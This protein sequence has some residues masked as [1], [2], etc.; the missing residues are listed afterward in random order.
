MVTHTEM[1]TLA[2]A[3]EQQADAITESK[4]S[5]LRG[6]EA[7]HRYALLYGEGLRRENRE[8][9]GGKPFKAVGSSGDRV[10]RHG[11]GQAMYARHRTVH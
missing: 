7:R 8:D 2:I 5:R 3:V 6:A 4:L 9:G 10:R 1:L 11:A